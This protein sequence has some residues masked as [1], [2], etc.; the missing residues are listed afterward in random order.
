[1]ASPP[2]IATDSSASIDL[3]DSSGA[4]MVTVAWSINKSA[5]TITFLAAA[6]PSSKTA[7]A[8]GICFGTRMQDLNAYVAWMDGDG[9]GH[10]ANYK[11]TGAPSAPCEPL[12]LASASPAHWQTQRCGTA[13]T[14][15]SG[16]LSI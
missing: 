9:H 8:V 6:H 13:S 10:V 7:G 5:D 12:S 4:V 2:R 16:P 15:F 11:T 1:M 3:V 14:H